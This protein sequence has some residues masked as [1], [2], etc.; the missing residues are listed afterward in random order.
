MDIRKVIDAHEFACLMGDAY[1][2]CLDMEVLENKQNIS[3]EDV[4]R[5]VKFVLYQEFD[6][7]VVKEIKE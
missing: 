7:E 1:S 5:V 3:F 6:V 2:N 4:E